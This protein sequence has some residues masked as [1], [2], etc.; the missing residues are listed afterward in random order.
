MAAAVSRERARN[1]QGNKR[2][3]G[4]VGGSRT[5][6][7]VD[8]GGGGRIKG[9]EVDAKEVAGLKVTAACVVRRR[10]TV[11][12]TERRLKAASRRGVTACES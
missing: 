4:K 1:D 10:R 5:L 11:S 7:N 12:W 8:V 3:W 2:P 6:E 9:G